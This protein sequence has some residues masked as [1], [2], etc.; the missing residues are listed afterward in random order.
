MNGSK[1]R[2]VGMACAVWISSGFTA[3]HKSDKNGAVVRIN[4]DST[5]LLAAAAAETG[6]GI[7][8]TLAQ[9]CA[10]E[11]GVPLEMVYVTD[12]DTAITPYDT[13]ATASRSLYRLGQ[14]VQCAAGDVRMQILAH[15]ARHLNVITNSLDLRDGVV[16]D[17]ATDTAL[18]LAQ[19]ARAAFKVGQEISAYGTSR[20]AMRRHLPPSLPKS[21]SI[22]KPGR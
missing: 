14:A 2:G 17:G 6:T 12:A 22:P 1:R 19:V 11:L 20:T 4:L 13:G 8:T 7:R 5:V 18:E 3:P 16:I 9:I 10:D 21:K 15:A